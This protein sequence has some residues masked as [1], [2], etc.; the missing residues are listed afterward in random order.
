MNELG[1]FW[2]DHWKLIL[3]GFIGV[4]I[5]VILNWWLRRIEDKNLLAYLTAEL[6]ALTTKAITTPLTAD[7]QAQ[8]QYL[9]G[10][11]YILDFKCK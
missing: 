3:I 5:G 4:A 11:I 8:V 6:N 7:E 2:R 1:I 10:E 9:K